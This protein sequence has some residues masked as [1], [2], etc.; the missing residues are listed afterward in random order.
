MAGLHQRRKV[1]FPQCL[2]HFKVPMDA[3]ALRKVGFQK[4]VGFTGGI[5]RPQR[6]RFY[7]S[8]QECFKLSKLHFE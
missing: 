7:Y 6:N 3:D 2:G 8:A 1:S 4:L 5:S